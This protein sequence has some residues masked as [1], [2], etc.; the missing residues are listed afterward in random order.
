MGALDGIKVVDLSRILAGPICAQ[1][2]GDHGAEI[3]KVEP[4]TGDE[5]RS[6]GPPFKDGQSAYFT[7][8]NRNKRSIAID[9]THPDGRALVLRMLEGADVLL[10]NFK[11]GTME[12]WGLG[13]HDVLAERFPRLVYCR[14]SGYGADGPL[15]GLPGYD[16]VAQAMGGVMDINGEPDGPPL[17]LSVPLS[18]FGAAY[19][20]VQGILLALFERTRSERG[21]F[22]ESTLLDATLALL[23]PQGAN[24][25]MSGQRPVRMGSSHPNISPYDCFP[26]GAGYIYIS[27]GNNRQFE[28]L[29]AELDVPEVA[30]DPRFA[31]NA[32]RVVHKVE[33]RALLESRFAAHE[34]GTLA[35]RLLARGVPAGAV[36]GVADAL[37]HP[38]VLHREMVVERPGYRGL[39][40]PIK[41]GR[42]PG[43]VGRIPPRFAEH[44]RELL[45]EA[46]L[47]DRTIDR[48]IGDGVVLEPGNDG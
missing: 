18:D 26:T 14:I 2:L 4:P 21:Q 15:G 22:V 43:A 27:C 44:S 41:L 38:Q 40:I 30:A 9:L 17:R 35:E 31:T 1:I 23:H 39:G 11:A 33:L 25:L 36:L 16:A 47:D 48:L 19:N 28:R 29:C 37:A 42:T 32:D 8:L 13:Y 20:A 45:A 34:A 5:T 6:W 46:G 7:G 10:E 12:K 24:Y 3:L